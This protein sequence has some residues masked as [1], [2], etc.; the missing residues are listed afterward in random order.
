MQCEEPGSYSS[1]LVSDAVHRDKK[2]SILF[3]AHV[4]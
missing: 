4:A 3:V 1:N 2:N